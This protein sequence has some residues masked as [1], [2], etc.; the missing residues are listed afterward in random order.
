VSAR[1][2]GARQEKRART[3]P[4]RSPETDSRCA[5]PD[6]WRAH[7]AAQGCHESAI[8]DSSRAVWPARMHDYQRWLDEPDA[9][10]AYLRALIGEH[11]EHKRS[12]RGCPMCIDD[13]RVQKARDVTSGFKLSFHEPTLRLMLASDDLLRPVGPV[14]TGGFLGH[15]GPVGGPVIFGAPPAGASAALLDEAALRAARM[16]RERGQ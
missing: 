15:N 9:L 5:L 1:A 12:V 7:D 2:E 16:R 10:V 8:V 3:C 13:A 14:W 11:P 6:T 4:A